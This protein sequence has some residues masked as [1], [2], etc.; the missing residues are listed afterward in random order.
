MRREVPKVVVL[1]NTVPLT[2]Q[3]EPRSI[4]KARPEGVMAAVISWTLVNEQIMSALFH[5]LAEHLE[6]LNII[7]I[8]LVT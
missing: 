4:H 3:E 7:F 5:Q 6:Y 1:G 2:T 8:K